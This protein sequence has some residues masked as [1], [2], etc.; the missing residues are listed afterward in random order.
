MAVVI[1]YGSL[2]LQAFMGIK[3][4]FKEEEY[5]WI[6]KYI[7]LFAFLFPLAL[8]TGVAVTENFNPA[9]SGTGNLYFHVSMVYR[10]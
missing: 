4:N 6:E 1:Y 3:H 2:I 7:H 8:S 5:R 9:G 10:K